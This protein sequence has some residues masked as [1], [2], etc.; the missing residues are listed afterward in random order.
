[1]SWE[2]NSCSPKPR[3]AEV[4]TQ[5]AAGDDENL[6]LGERRQPDVGAGSGELL[7]AFQEW[8]MFDL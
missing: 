3:P 6:V 8:V 5:L 7:V 4:F 2:S 1:M